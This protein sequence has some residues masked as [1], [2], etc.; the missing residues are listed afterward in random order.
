MLLNRKSLRRPS[1]VAR[2]QRLGKAVPCSTTAAS[3]IAQL[4]N[5]KSRYFG[6]IHLNNSSS[7][8]QHVFYRLG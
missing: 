5:L 4:K 2:K 7:T 6:H 1:P 8:S 3:V